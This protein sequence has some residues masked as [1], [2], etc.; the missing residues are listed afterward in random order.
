M[1]KLFEVK[2][3]FSCR[4]E[5][6]SQREANE[7]AK[8]WFEDNSNSDIG[9]HGIELIG[10]VE[11]GSGACVSCGRLTDNDCSECNQPLC[12]DIDECGPCPCLEGK[13]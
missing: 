9:L 6:D 3:K 7:T 2:G 12:N 13:K 5:A 8:K 4:V 10:S 1:T 11:V